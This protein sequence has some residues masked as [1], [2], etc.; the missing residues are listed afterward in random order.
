MSLEII[1]M[2]FQ[3]KEIRVHR[4]DATFHCSNT[5]RKYRYFF[6]FFI[7]LTVRISGSVFFSYDHFYLDYDKCSISIQR[8]LS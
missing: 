7:G 6:A 1:K 3:I 4:M 5:I 2:S 8:R